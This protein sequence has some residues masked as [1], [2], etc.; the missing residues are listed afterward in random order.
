MQI[1]S[2]VSGEGDS[3]EAGSV[4]VPLTS[5][6]VLILPTEGSLDPGNS[7]LKAGY[8]NPNVILQLDNY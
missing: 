7:N 5:Q 4:A 6:R 1:A 8:G 3:D 2:E